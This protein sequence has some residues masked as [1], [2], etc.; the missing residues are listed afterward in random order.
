MWG[1]AVQLYAVRSRNTWG[2]GDLGDLNSLIR[3]LAPH[4]AGFIGLNPLH[5]LAPADPLRSSPYSASSRHFLN[6]LYIAVP[7][8]PEFSECARARAAVEDPQFRER[9]Q[10]LRSADLVDYRGVADAKFE[11]L[12]LLFHQFRDQHLNQAT[13]RG[14]CY[15][16]FVSGGG[17]LLQAHARFDALDQHFRASRAADSGWFSS[18]YAYPHVVRH[19]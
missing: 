4:G 16:G 17:A 19:A 13:D 2:I 7:L 8:V 10:R 5:A 12:E 11:I 1:I 15:R 14:Q 6:I 3:W 9:L 18:T